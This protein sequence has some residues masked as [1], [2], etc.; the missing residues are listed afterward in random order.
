MFLFW[1]YAKVTGN[2]RWKAMSWGMVP[3]LGGAMSACVWHTFYNSPELG[4]LVVLQA[5]LTIVGNATCWAAAYYIYQ[6]A[7][8]EKQKGAQ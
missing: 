6:G 4:F 1:E 2:E 3:S 8:E 7:Q 5:S